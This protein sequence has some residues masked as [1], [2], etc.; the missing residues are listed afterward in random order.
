MPELQDV[1]LDWDDPSTSSMESAPQL[2]TADC[3][4]YPI[5]GIA[6]GDLWRGLTGTMGANGLIFDWK[7]AG[8]GT[9]TALTQPADWFFTID[10]PGS[11]SSSWKIDFMMNS[12]TSPIDTTYMGMVGAGGGTVSSTFAGINTPNGNAFTAYEVKLEVDTTFTSPTQTLTVNVTPATTIDINPAAVPEPAS[13]ALGAIG[14]A[15]LLYAKVRQK[16]ANRV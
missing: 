10:L 2:V 15:A 6:R 8:S 9:F 3:D 7:G 4:S 1:E 16:R 5:R 14:F 12:T 13:M 11:T